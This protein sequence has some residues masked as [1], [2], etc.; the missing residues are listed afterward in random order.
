MALQLRDLHAV[1]EISKQYVVPP[2]QPVHTPV[3]LR[4]PLDPAKVRRLGIT[5]E[6]DST[7]V[8]MLNDNNQQELL[9]GTLLEGWVVESSASVR[10]RLTMT[11][12]A[13]GGDVYLNGTG[14]LLNPELMMYLASRTSSVLSLSLL[15]DERTCVD[16]EMIPGLIKIGQLADLDPVPASPGSGLSINRIAPN[17]FS[18]YV[19]INY[20]TIRNAPVRL[21]IVDA[22]GRTVQTLIDENV[23]AGN[24]TVRWSSR[25]FSPGIY[26][27]QLETDGRTLV[28][29]MV[30]VK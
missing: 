7:C 27:C 14:M 18:D 1:A 2:G 20:S 15:L 13:P 3:M 19:D 28:A 9:A 21:N 4:H 17:P 6:Y 25:S 11:L 24:H 16:L 29:R 12:H 5:L 8:I 23:V 26:F 10:G 22:T 30:L